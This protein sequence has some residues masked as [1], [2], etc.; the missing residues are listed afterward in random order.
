ENSNTLQ[1]RVYHNVIS[2]SFFMQ[3]CN[4]HLSF[5]IQKTIGSVVLI[6][7]SV[8]IGCISGF[9]LEQQNILNHPIP[10]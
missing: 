9:I 2:P 6:Q 3:L 1:K 5:V 8:L 10:N 7:A 4:F